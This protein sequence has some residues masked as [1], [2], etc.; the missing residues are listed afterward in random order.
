MIEQRRW[1]KQCTCRGA[2]AT[3]GRF[4]FV[5]ERDGQHVYFYPGPVCD[6]CNTPWAL[7]VPIIVP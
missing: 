6:S 7:A 5:S 1:E 2:T 3:S 4:V